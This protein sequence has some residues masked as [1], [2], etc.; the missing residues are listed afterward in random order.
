LRRA[1]P[2]VFEIAEQLTQ[3]LIR[4]LRDTELAERTAKNMAMHVLAAKS[5]ELFQCAI[6]LLEG[7]CIPAA[8]IVCRA[9]LETVYRLVAIQLS[10]EAIDLYLQQPS[11]TRL[12]KLKSVV[13]YKQKHKK[14]GVAPGVEAEINCL[15]K[16]KPM[17]TE[18]SAWA[19]LAQMEDF[20]NLYYQGMSDDVHA[21]IESLNHYF[22]ESST[23]LVSFGPSDKDLTTVAA[24][25]HRTMLNAIEKYA[26]FLN[27]DVSQ[28]LSGL[29]RRIDAIEERDG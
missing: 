5:L 10:P 22:D 7:G 28:Q 16:Q 21:N 27:V 11:Q 3:L 26:R 9:L 19:K 15:S 12:Q 29:S 20:H 23:H 14:C 13:K 25:C 6:L 18:P 2:E 8:K 4:P 1:Y 24:A 17:K